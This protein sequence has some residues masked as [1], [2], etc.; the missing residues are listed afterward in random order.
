MQFVVVADDAVLATQTKEAEEMRRRQAESADAQAHYKSKTDALSMEIDSL[1]GQPQVEFDTAM[2]LLV[3][4]T[5][6]RQSEISDEREEFSAVCALYLEEEKMLEEQI[7]EL[8]HEAADILKKAEE[9]K[10]QVE[11]A[12]K[13]RR[14]PP[15]CFSLSWPL[16]LSAVL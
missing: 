16:L 11:A 7:Q 12:E 2:A 4:D 15:P 10:A 14:H 1:L 6:A 5:M 9:H 3:P 8:R 13:V